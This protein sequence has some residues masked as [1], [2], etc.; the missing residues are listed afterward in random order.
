MSHLKNNNTFVKVLKCSQFRK[1]HKIFINIMELKHLFSMED[2]CLNNC[3]RSTIRDRNILY[4]GNS[5]G[6]KRIYVC[7]RR[8]INIHYCTVQCGNFSDGL[9]F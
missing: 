8:E 1:I 4:N 9:K 3:Y 5:K 7:V 6:G 2:S